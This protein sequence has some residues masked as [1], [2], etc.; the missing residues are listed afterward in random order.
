MIPVLDLFAGAVGGWSLGL[1]RAG[2]TTVA[3]CEIDT[4][5]RA[6]FARNFPE[7]RLYDDI[8]TLTAA[9]LRADGVVRPYVIA[10]SPPCQDA[11]AAN[12]SG[13]GVDGERTGLYREWLRLVSEL[14]PA[15]TC[16]ENSPR[17]RTRG[18]DRLLGELES[19]DYTVW[20]LVVSAG[21]VGAPHQR[22]R[23]W[24]VA[25]DTEN[26][27]LIGGRS[28]EAVGRERA[29][30]AGHVERHGANSTGIECRARGQGRLSS[31]SWQE[32]RSGLGLDGDR[33]GADAASERCGEGRP[34]DAR[35]QGR[36][37]AA[38]RLGRDGS[39]AN[40]T[41]QALRPCEPED[42]CE[43]FPAA[44]RTWAAG[45]SHWNGGVAGLAAAYA[46]ERAG[47]LA[48]GAAARLARPTASDFATDRF[49][50]SERN[51]R[52]SAGGDAIVPQVAEAIGRAIRGLM[53]C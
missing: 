18:V 16:V 45:W 14:R 47:Q 21:D 27:G 23:V 11:S 22:E 24:I 19:L 9:R 49:A 12:T 30:P 35:Q 13:R 17:L 52:I 31:A 34:R 42:P 33:D 1:H 50:S 8:R 44:L 6:A 4:W 41:R 46:A 39:D 37:D 36:S 5:R 2:F 51:R 43:E 48:D 10:G 32:G 15:W 25:A 3:A 53:P 28:A 26:V 29:E 20:P 40:R 38:Q 7:A